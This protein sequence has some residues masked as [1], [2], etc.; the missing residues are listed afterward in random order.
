MSSNISGINQDINTSISHSRWMTNCKYISEYNIA[1]LDYNAYYFWQIPVVPESFSPGIVTKS[2]LFIALKNSHADA[3]R[4]HCK[5]LCKKKLS[6]KYIREIRECRKDTIYEWETRRHVGY[7]VYC[8]NEKIASKLKFQLQ[9]YTDSYDWQGE[10]KSQYAPRVCYVFDW[11]AKK[12]I[13][14]EKAREKSKIPSGPFNFTLDPNTNNNNNKTY[15]QFAQEHAQALMDGTPYI[16]KLQQLKEEY[17]R[18]E[19]RQK[20]QKN[21]KHEKHGAGDKDDK[22]DKGE[23]EN[24]QDKQD[25]AQVQ[26][27]QTCT[28]TTIV[29]DVL[30]DNFLTNN[31]CHFQISDKV[32]LMQLNKADYHR[33]MVFLASY[34]RLIEIKCKNYVKAEE[35][36]LE[37]IH[38][39]Q[40]FY[41]MEKKVHSKCNF[42]LVCLMYIYYVNMMSNALL[43]FANA[44]RYCSQAIE[45]IVNHGDKDEHNFPYKQVYL[46]WF[47]CKYVLLAMKM[48]ENKFDEYRRI[49]SNIVES[50]RKNSS[51]Y[52]NCKNIELRINASKILNVEK[53]QHSIY[54]FHG[55]IDV[56]KVLTNISLLKADYYYGI[57]DYDKYKE[58]LSDICKNNRSGIKRLSKLNV[59]E[60]ELAR[61]LRYKQHSIVDTIGIYNDMCPDPCNY[62]YRFK[63]LMA[64]YKLRQYKRF[65][66]Q[67]RYYQRLVTYYKMDDYNKDQLLFEL[68]L[69]NT[70]SLIKNGSIFNGITDDINN[71][72]NINDINGD[73]DDDDEQEVILYNLKQI[74]TICQRL[75][76]KLSSID[77]KNTTRKFCRHSLFTHFCDI[78]SKYFELK[79]D[80]T[81]SLVIL[82]IGLNKL[83]YFKAENNT[84]D[85]RKNFYFNNDTRYDIWQYSKHF[86]KRKQ[87]IIKYK[88]EK[89]K[90]SFNQMVVANI[91]PL[92]NEVTQIIL[93]FVFIDE[94]S[95]GDH[96][97][98]FDLLKKLC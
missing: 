46:Q 27:V 20:Q 6:R 96:K 67:V 74:Q 18:Q 33:H 94:L 68:L 19:K 44:R 95:L 13:K 66:E 17:Q 90:K 87:I 22:G 47:R 50:K 32:R 43:M 78:F 51:F 49:L 85:S 61:I 83:K 77:D 92:P 64:L 10:V 38:L 9:D 15:D 71:I 79:Y 7:I 26:S 59:T 11:F 76:I 35:C 52:N 3:W 28:H 42:E 57:E 2:L 62:D 60:I 63:I 88:V 89:S 45:L 98:C 21:E 72:N 58:Y 91:L 54:N 82:Q 34:G 5:H 36:Y 69:L 4:S 81:T 31:H 65:N 53:D 97:F 93:D 70:E 86:E 16:Y 1:I 23:K 80:L 48:G 8:Q 14:T 12:Y 39:C 41:T 25:E 30:C 56:E 40:Q 73:D 84:S 29:S 37:A 55:E 24:K 75:K